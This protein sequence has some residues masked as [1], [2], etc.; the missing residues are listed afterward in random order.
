MLRKISLILII[1]SLTGL[2]SAVDLESKK[3]ASRQAAQ[4]FGKTLKGELVAA[5][6]AGGPMNAVGVCNL[7]ALK[8]AE[9]VS[10][11]NG[12]TISRTS[13]KFRNTDNAPTDWQQKILIE[14]D[15]KN[16]ADQ[17][18]T[19]LEYAELVDTDSGQ[20]FR[21]MKAIPTTEVCL[22]CHGNELSDEL[23]AKIMELYPEDH[24]TGFSVG[25]IRGAFV[26]VDKL[27]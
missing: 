18:P 3:V 11:E 8:I 19:K 12:L 2:T 14:F 9:S 17:D 27:N 13:L 22:N 7:E 1:T 15:Q 4:A 16:S 20:E 6:N 25:D 21:Y 26:V 10:T 23:T 24:A 5:M